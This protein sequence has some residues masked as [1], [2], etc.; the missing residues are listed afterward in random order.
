ML[1]LSF[2]GVTE[3]DWD[4]RNGEETLGDTTG[5]VNNGADTIAYPED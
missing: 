2:F 5:D 3:E 1:K 4:N